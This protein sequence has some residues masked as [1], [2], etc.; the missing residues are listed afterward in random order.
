MTDD[1]FRSYLKQ[2]KKDLRKDIFE[3]YPEILGQV[4]RKYNHTCIYCEFEYGKTITGRKLTIDHKVPL[5]RGGTNDL[6]NL[7]SACEEHNTEKRD[8]TAEE[9]FHV[10]RRKKGNLIHS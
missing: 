6:K 1:E 8:M 10:L 2:K 9:Y 3:N 4:L 5:A 7:C